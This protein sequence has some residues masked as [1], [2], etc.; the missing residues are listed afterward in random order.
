MKAIRLTFGVIALAALGVLIVPA[1][2][3]QV[4]HQ[5]SLAKNLTSASLVQG[6]GTEQFV[7]Q[8][9]DS[10]T[11]AAPQQAAQASP[12]PD[13]GTP[14]FVTVGIPLVILAVATLIGLGFGSR[15][16]TN[17]S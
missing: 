2:K 3:A 17:H 13:N 12:E 10:G 9:T 15:H 6:A 16:S 11:A 1:A 4:S 8:A 5:M 14:P 7:A